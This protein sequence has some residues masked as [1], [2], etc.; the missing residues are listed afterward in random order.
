MKYRMPFS[1]YSAIWRSY[2]ASDSWALAITAKQLLGP[3]VSHVALK[4]VPCSWKNRLQLFNSTSASTNCWKF[5]R[6]KRFQLPNPIE[7]DF[8]STDPW[9]C[10]RSATF[11]RCGSKECGKNHAELGKSRGPFSGSSIPPLL[12][13]RLV[14]TK[15][16]SRCCVYH[17]CISHSN[18][19]LFLLRC[20]LLCVRFTLHNNHE[21][22]S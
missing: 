21:L 9:S 7:A 18:L 5:V 1:T 20:Y 15:C 16:Y 4:Y 2:K 22:H 8:I 19:L 17:L 11:L 14:R 13:S 12:L 6:L 3:G 10:S